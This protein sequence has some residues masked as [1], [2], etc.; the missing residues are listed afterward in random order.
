[1]VNTGV[2]K[3]SGE[4]TTVLPVT[5]CFVHSGCSVEPSWLYLRPRQLQNPSKAAVYISQ[6][7]KSRQGE[8]KCFLQGHSFRAEGEWRGGESLGPECREL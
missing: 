7:R 5:M 2:E 3:A 1:M 8:M 4:K 6:T